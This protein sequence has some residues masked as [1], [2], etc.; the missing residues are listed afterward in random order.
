M[1]PSAR[2]S[3]LLASLTVDE[4]IAQL[5]GIWLGYDEGGVV[6]PDMDTLDDTAPEFA[7]Y[8]VHGM[9]QLTRVYGTKPVL[10]AEGLAT[11][12]GCQK[13]IRDHT[14]RPIGVL[15]HEECLT[16]LAAWT[17]TTFPTPLATAAAFD[18]AITFAMGAAIG[19]SV[20]RLG[21]HQGLSP[22]LDVVRDV[23][24]GRVEETMGED[25]YVIGTLGKAYVE[26]LQSTGIIAT[27]KHYAG[28]SNSR[29]GRN[30]AP[31][32]AGPRELED[33]FLIPFEIA[34]LDGHA[35]SVMPAYVDI[36]GVP[37]HGDRHLLTEILR[38]RWGFEGTVVADYFGI[39]FLKKEHGV[40]ATLTEAAAEALLA[41][42]DVELP[43]AD[44]FHEAEFAELCRRDPAVAAALDTAVTRVLIQKETLGLLDIDAEIARLEA[45]LADAP[46]TLDPPE[47]RAI[48]AGLAEESVILMANNGALPLAPRPGL[49]IGVVGPNADREAALFGCY[50]FIN[51]VLAH[52]PGVESRVAAPT[53]L[54]ALRAEYGADGVAYAA[55]CDVRG[56]CRGGIADAVALAER[57]D[58]VIAVMGDQAGLFGEG[59][60]GE[61]C[62][63]DSLALPGV[64]PELVEALLATGTPVI[65]VLVTGRPYAVGAYSERAAATVQAFFPGEEGAA[66]V[67][68][69]LSGRV[70][71]SGHL[72]VSVPRSLGV[73]PY[74]YLHPK[75]GDPGS[76]SSI[77]T[78]PQFSFGHGLSYTTFEFG[79]FTVP[80]T[81]PTDGW[82]PV[83]VVVKNSGSREGTTLVQVYGHDVVA[84]VTR[85]LKQLLG[86][87]RVRLGA[88]ESRLVTLEIPTAR[89]AFHNREMIRVV[90][91]GEVRVWLGWDCD[92]PATEKRAVQLTGG[93]A[94]VT[95]DTPRLVTV[96]I[97]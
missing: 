25:P 1:Q 32:H 2:V 63:V 75:L 66:A 80:E 5:Y 64:Q 93:A 61:G 69:V 26:G 45:L 53:I 22:V 71:P 29:A 84:S 52:N 37:V 15:A 57:S 60:S 20:A 7:D 47:H 94:Q 24:W 3:D 44:A 92:H 88:G 68:G 41:G 85:P 21:V 62:D 4:K 34:L 77:D 28:Y 30:L 95:G 46:A 51:H 89:L 6:A 59:T 90:E 70:N 50:S 40:V 39:A 43:S 17:A 79:E 10:P 86:Y 8:A 56:D 9:S 18:P 27:L 54:E 14:R 67:A 23:R 72:P 19:E 31:V 48:A 38:E 11:L 13:W 91:P 35:G 55:G 49:R 81:A 97:A 74:S 76:V 73:L 36:D 83:S 87:A 33:V 16:G 96:S 42:V 12:I 78:T 58:V 65:L 82:I